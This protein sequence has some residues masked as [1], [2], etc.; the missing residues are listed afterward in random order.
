[1]K[2]NFKKLEVEVKFDEFVKV[3]VAKAVANA[4]HTST[5]DIG[6]DDVARSIYYSEGEIDFPEEFLQETLA[7]IKDPRCSLVA[8]VKKAVIKALTL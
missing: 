8:S 2:V 4:I 5:S 6:L 7:I 1:M 3:D